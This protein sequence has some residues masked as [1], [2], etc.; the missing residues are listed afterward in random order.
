MAKMSLRDA[1]GMSKQTKTWA[2]LAAMAVLAVTML[3]TRGQY[4][5]LGAAQAQENQAQSQLARLQGQLAQLNSG[6]CGS[7]QTLVGQFDQAVQVLPS[8]KDESQDQAQVLNSLPAQISS[9]GLTLGSLSAQGPI[10]GPVSGV[11]GY[12][13]A[14]S[15]SGSL[16]A[17]ES[18]I[19]AISSASPLVT[20]TTGA[21]S[22]GGAASSSNTSG[23]T[24][25]TT[26]ASSNG[27]FSL[28]ATLTYWYTSQTSPLGARAAA[29]SSSSPSTSTCGS[30]GAS[31]SATTTTTRPHG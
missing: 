7:Y 29:P 15:M 22:S 24:P 12:P 25:P 8:I 26:P 9:S 2:V 31:S 1:K 11:T 5:D 21:L 3:F 23:Q 30:N 19:N 28:T 18:W 10:S 27:E 14:V 16:D 6:N 20:L 4:S 17:I 13:M